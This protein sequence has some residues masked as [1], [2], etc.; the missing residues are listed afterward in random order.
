MG[1]SGHESAATQTDRSVELNDLR[2]FPLMSKDNWHDEK[3][4]TQFY[5]AA[6][7]IVF[8]ATAVISGAEGAER[9]GNPLKF[10]EGRTESVST[11]KVITKKPYR[12]RS[13]GLGQIRSDGTLYLVQRVEEGARTPFD[14]RWRI[15]QTGPGRFSGTMSEATGPVTIAE[16]RGGFRFRFKM[17]GNLSVEQWLTP[18]P[19]GKSA[20]TKVTIRKLGLTVGSSDGTIRKLSG[21]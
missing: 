17:K 7:P 2:R 18:L 13:L 14:R 6:V 20:R 19:D 8:M 9:P 11:V 16:I 4:M 10:F 5:I 12:S 21:S 15:R 1:G 3:C